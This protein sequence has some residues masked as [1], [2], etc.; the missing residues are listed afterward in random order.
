ME[1]KSKNPLLP[2]LIVDDEFDALQSYKSLLRYNGFD[3]LILCSESTHATQ[4]LS[5]ERVSIV[6]L[7]LNMPGLTGQELLETLNQQYPE[8][9][10]IVITAI[11]KIE[12]A[13]H[14]MKLGAFDYMIK[15]VEKSH[16]SACIF[17]ALEIFELKQ[18]VRLLKKQVLSRKLQNPEN[19]NEIITNNENMKSIFSYIEAIAS[20]SKPVLITGESGTGKELIARAVYK[21]SRL[22][23][24][25]VAVNVAGLEDTIF[26]DTLFGHTKGAFTGA[27]SPRQGLIHNAENGVLFLDEIGDLDPKSQVKL[28]RLLQEK[29][30]SP[31]GSDTPR[32]S[33]A[34][35]IAATN[36]DISSKSEADLFRKDLYYRLATHHIHIP[37]LRERLDD[38]PLL[39]EAFVEEASQSM[40]KEKPQIPRELRT[41]LGSYS[42]PGNIRELQSM[43][44]DAMARHNSGVLSLEFF[45]DYIQNRSEKKEIEEIT[46]EYSPIILPP[47]RFPTL[48]EVEDYLF[49]EAMQ[50][51]EG[52]Q[53]IAARLLG[54]SQSTL[55]RRFRQKVG[56]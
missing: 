37:P 9:P 5:R 40:K 56:E 19:F 28:L 30:Y 46:E 6:I 31:L 35:I 48:R 26:S 4:L 49:S 8:I 25:F 39:M 50:R 34:R 13:V 41:L 51:S 36:A 33:N 14:C 47:D 2:I 10:V 16:L 53:S 29:E 52:N 24:N 32:L 42:F 7:D 17:R 11:D 44:Y 15:P 12:T 45:R 54:V 22:Q 55:S 38:L 3:N 27:D 21:Q 1:E 43:I 23:G 18:E 20:S